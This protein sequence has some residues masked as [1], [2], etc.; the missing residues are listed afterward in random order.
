M[1]KR[2]LKNNVYAPSDLSKYLDDHTRDFIGRKWVFEKIDEWLS[3]PDAPRFF[4]ITGEPGIGKTAIAARLAQTRDLAA[5]HFCIKRHVDTIDPFNFVSSCSHQ[6]NHIDGFTIGIL[7]EQ[8]YTMDIKNIVR[9]NYGQVIG[10]DI[11]NMFF[12]SKSVQTHFNRLVADPLKRLYMKKFDRQLVILVDALDEAVQ[13]SE[14]EN[15]S[16][17]IVDLLINAQGLPPQV[18][19]ILT[20]RPESDVQRH[21]KHLNIPYLELNAGLEKNLQ[22]VKDYISFKLKQSRYLQKRL[23]EK[24]IQ[25]EEFI[26][27]VV[28]ASKGNF[29]YV[30]YLLPA[31]EKGKQEFDELQDLPDGLE[32]IYI[33]FLNTRKV[34]KTSKWPIY[35]KL[36]G[37]L[38]AAQEP[39]TFEHLVNFTGKNE[40]EVHII[41]QDVRQFLDSTSFEN[42]QYQLYH[43][44]IKDF[45]ND[46]ELADVFWIDLKSV[47]KTIAQYYLNKYSHNWLDCDYY[48]LRHIPRHLIEAGD[49]AHLRELF[50]DFSW[51]CAKLNATDVIHLISDLNLLKS[52][53]N[54]CTVQDTLY[55]A[56]HILQHDKR[57]LATQLH[58]RLISNTDPDIQSIVKQVSKWKGDIWLR[59]MTASLLQ[60]GSPLKDTLEGHDWIESVTVTPDGRRAISGLDNGT[61]KVWDL[62]TRE[63][64]ASLEGHT[65]RVKSVTVTPDGHRVISGSHDGTLKVWDIE[66][67]VQLATLEGHIDWVESVTVTPDGRRA[68]SGSDDGT[69]K[70]WDLK[71]WKQLATLEGHTDSVRSVTV[72]PDG[73]RAISGSD[74]GTLK[75]WDLKTWKQLATLEGHIDSVRS[76]TVTPDGSRAISGSFDRT[77]KVWDLETWKQLAPLKVITGSVESVTVTPDGRYVI[78]GSDYGTLKVWNLETGEQLATLKDSG[79]WV[80]SVTVTP[81][82]RHAISGSIDGRLMVWDMRT[83]EQLTTTEDHACYVNSVTVTPDGRCAI[84]GSDDGTLKVWDM[85]TGK[86]LATLKGHTCGVHS[87]TVT[88]DSR[89]VVSVSNDWTLKIWDLKKGVQLPLLKVITDTIDS[90]TVTPDGRRAILITSNKTPKVWNLETRKLETVLKDQTVSFA[91]VTVTPDGHRAILVSGV[92]TLK[93]W[94]LETGVQLTTLRGHTDWIKSLTVTPDGYRVISVSYDSTPK[95]WDLKTGEQ[96]ATLEGLTGLV[97]SVTVTPDSR[98][99]I[100]VSDDKTL[101]VWEIETGEQLAMLGSHND[102]VMPVTVTPD[103]RRAISG[104][105]DRTLK[106]WDMESWDI[107]TSFSGDAHLTA[108]AV[109]PDGLTIVAGDFSGKV[110]ILRIEE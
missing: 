2:S 110:H 47:H 44:S 101:K 4:I 69:L 75:V 33:E 103:G 40:Q 58:G 55:L 16:G 72:T 43:Q 49:I 109:S 8:G 23:A 84:S 80:E 48:G 97:N 91:P 36:F 98:R 26:E 92:S 88:L 51:L 5:V 37:V 59:L 21:F 9:E 73:R 89:R 20:S 56:A 74:D 13:F 99:V 93:V 100:S 35:Q 94:D 12:E 70:V 66:K 30:V 57:Q 32:S 1:E 77:L 39:L 104:S 45:L 50:L 53:T 18:R 85:E 38:V 62:E 52:D 7:E 54:V 78:S 17:N 68:I 63:Q 29:L 83:D 67:G 81:D 76:V 64:L 31:I 107:I 60:P 95:V 71:T 79:S 86:Q 46:K 61:L 34:G 14:S 96:L 82:G 105:F 25:S 11:K 108:C 27:N 102:W 19:F 10:V 22:D 42:S 41:L 65:G 90:A 3:T 15:I 6:F 87:V 28:T 24:N 106:V